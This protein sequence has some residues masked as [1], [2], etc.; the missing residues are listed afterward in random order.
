MEGSAGLPESWQSQ[1]P[2]LPVPRST[3]DSFVSER[4]GSNYFSKSSNAVED[5]NRLDLLSGSN[6]IAWAYWQYTGGPRVVTSLEFVMDVPAGNEY[7]VAVPDY[8]AGRWQ[9][10][11]PF[12]SGRVFRA[13]SFDFYSPA[14]DFFA[15]ALTA[16][17]N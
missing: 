1:L 17:G 4:V 11:G 12:E 3:S 5:G 16:A 10:R 9:F 15:L 8:R 14:G 6:S 13:D 7:Y 2:P